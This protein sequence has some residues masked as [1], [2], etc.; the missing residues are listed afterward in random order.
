MSQNLP[1]TRRFGRSDL[2][3]SVVGYIP[4]VRASALIGMGC[5]SLAAA[6]VCYGLL[7][8]SSSVEQASSP[9]AKDL[10][11]AVLGM[12][13]GLPALVLGLTGILFLIAGM[14]VRAYRS[15][16]RRE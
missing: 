11:V 15:Y 1:F 4:A 6:L 9:G 14:G 10:G 3:A 13:F 16:F 2:N 12:L 7:E 8:W 5:S